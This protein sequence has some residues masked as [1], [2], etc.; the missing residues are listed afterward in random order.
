M[1][2]LEDGFDQVVA[3]CI[4]GQHEDQGAAAQNAANHVL[5]SAL[6]LDVPLFA[7]TRHV[8]D[9]G[10]LDFT[11]FLVPF[12]TPTRSNSCAKPWTVKP[13]LSWTQAFRDM[14]R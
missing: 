11:P 1:S 14:T 6:R 5:D 7:D 12:A 9:L 13:R 4:L 2:T 8:S 3:V 10:S